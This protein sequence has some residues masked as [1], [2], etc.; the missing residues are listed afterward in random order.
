MVV[1]CFDHAAKPLLK[2]FMSTVDKDVIGTNFNCQ[3]K[4][5]ALITLPD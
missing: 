5:Q 3:G 4:M 2:E 1:I